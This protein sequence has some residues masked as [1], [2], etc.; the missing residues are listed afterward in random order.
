MKESPAKTGPTAEIAE[1]ANKQTDAPENNDFE[2]ELASNNNY[3]VGG[4]IHRG[5]TGNGEQFTIVQ[6]GTEY[7]DADKNMNVQL[8][9]KLRNFDLSMLTKE[10]HEG[11]YDDKKVQ[12]IKYYHKISRFLGEAHTKGLKVITSKK[13]K[14]RIIDGSRTIES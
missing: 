13:G 6:D 9:Y 2:A 7:E 10:V 14:E 1:L 3:I 12:H 8:S 11:E 5:I 4:I